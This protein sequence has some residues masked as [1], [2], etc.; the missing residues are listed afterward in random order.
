MF[1]GHFVKPGTHLFSLPTSDYIWG[2]PL[3]GMCSLRPPL[4]VPFST[5]LARPNDQE[6]LLANTLGETHLK[7]H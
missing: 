7:I 1:T 4:V 3:H 6:F 5:N 2:S